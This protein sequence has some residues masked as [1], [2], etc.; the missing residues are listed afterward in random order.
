MLELVRVKGSKQEKLYFIDRELDKLYIPARN[1]KEKFMNRLKDLDEKID[2]WF[3]L[4]DA[5]SLDINEYY[6]VIYRVNEKDTYSIKE[7][8]KAEGGKWNGNYWILPK[9]SKKFKT[10][11][12]IEWKKKEV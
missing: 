8:I 7:E 3:D 9:E 5:E 10:E 11:I 2:D 1:Y 6:N 12:F 4:E